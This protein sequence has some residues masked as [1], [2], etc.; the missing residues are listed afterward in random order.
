MTYYRPYV[1]GPIIYVENLA[2]EFVRRGHQVTF[3][4]SRHELTAPR[5]ERREGVRILRLP[6]AARISKG[7][8]MPRLPFTAWALIRKH[9]VV[10]VQVPQFEAPLLAMLGKLAGVPV[11]LVYHC[12]VELPPGWWN[13]AVNRV[14]HWSAAAAARL[15]S[16]IVA[17]TQ[18]YARHSPVMSR[19]ENKVEVIPPPVEIP[20]ASQ[21][22][23]DSFRR[24]HGLTGCT[25]IGVCG[26]IAAEKGL[27]YLVDCLPSLAERYPNL[28]V[29]HAGETAG[30]IGEAA[31]NERLRGKLDRLAARWTCL[32]V[33][34][35]EQLAAFYGA[36]DVTVL[37]SVNRT[38]SFGLVQ[39]ES[40]LSGTPVVASDLPGVRVPVRTTGM[41]R[42]V[43][44][45]DSVA[46]GE[47]VLEVLEHR[48]DYE[49]PREAVEAEYSARRTARGYEALFAGMRLAIGLESCLDGEAPVASKSDS[50]L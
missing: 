22:S 41:G 42:I 32:G 50:P 17:Y 43:R 21:E 24:R 9:D 46:L 8:L 39:V 1:S 14:M 19:F 27:E 20:R 37:P 2:A 29:L 48:G 3:L 15:S 49:K 11:V 45:A 28:R 23:V 10:L 5:E 44:P 40:M 35:R 6:V 12:D 31:Y 36:C 38:E 13:K 30:V 47:A 7:V 25:V 16:R 4:T 18:D 33:L 34:D 26:R